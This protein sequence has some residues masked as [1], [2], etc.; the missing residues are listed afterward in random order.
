MVTGIGEANSALQHIV[1]HDKPSSCISH[2]LACQHLL[3]EESWFVVT[4]PVPSALQ[5]SALLMLLIVTV[6]PS[7]P[8]AASV[9][10]SKAA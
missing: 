5:L 2:L 6:G 10:G 4:V 1:C 7:V 8:G 9:L 3:L